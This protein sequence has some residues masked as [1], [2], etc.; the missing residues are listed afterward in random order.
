MGHGL[1]LHAAAEADCVE[2]GCDHFGCL[3]KQPQSW[4]LDARWNSAVATMMGPQLDQ[5]ASITDIYPAHQLA[6]E[7]KY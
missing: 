4:S 1:G 3:P 7:K 5:S 2:A 6:G